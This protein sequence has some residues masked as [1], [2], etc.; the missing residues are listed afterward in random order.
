M[1]GCKKEGNCRYC[2]DQTFFMVTYL[3]VKEDTTNTN[4]FTYRIPQHAFI[5]TTVLTYSLHT[6]N[7]NNHVQVSNAPSFRPDSYELLD[8]THFLGA[9]SFSGPVDPEDYNNPF[10]F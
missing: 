7:C 4:F 10:G 8:F 1:T 3:T 6:G 2:D 9:A 5:I